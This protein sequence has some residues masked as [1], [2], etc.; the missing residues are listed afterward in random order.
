[1]NFKRD[2]ILLEYIPTYTPVF[3]NWW[4]RERERVRVREKELASARYFTDEGIVLLY[5]W[6]FEAIYSVT[7]PGVAPG[8]MDV[9]SPWYP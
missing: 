7:Q 9:I 3:A 5:W 6:G 2:S 8:W 1:M 4:E